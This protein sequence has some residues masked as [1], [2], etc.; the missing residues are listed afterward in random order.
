MRWLILL[1]SAL[2]LAAPAQALT[3]TEARS[4][5]TGEV[6]SRITALNAVLATADEKTVALIQAMSDDSVKFTDTAVFVM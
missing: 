4:L 3:P 5:A 2:V 1:M 6:E